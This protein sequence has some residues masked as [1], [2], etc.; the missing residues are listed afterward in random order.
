MPLIQIS[1]F[2]RSPRNPATSRTIGVA[3]QISYTCGVEKIYFSPTVLFQSRLYRFAVP[4]WWIFGVGGDWFEVFGSAFGYPKENIVYIYVCVLYMWTKKV[5]CFLS[6]ETTKKSHIWFPKE[7]PMKIPMMQEI[8]T[9]L[10]LFRK[11]TPTALNCHAFESPKVTNPSS[12]ALPYSWRVVPMEEMLK[13]GVWWPKLGNLTQGKSMQRKKHILYL[14]W[15]KKTKALEFHGAWELGND[16][17]LFWETDGLFFRGR[18]VVSFRVFSWKIY[19]CIIE[20]D[21]LFLMIIRRFFWFTQLP[22]L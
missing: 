9:N 22:I 2:R 3:D 11:K 12:I 7:K 17:F 21:L 1:E 14:P 18:S 13:V 16:P 5:S 15:S 8:F 4:G 19:G 20:S 10:Q 6:V